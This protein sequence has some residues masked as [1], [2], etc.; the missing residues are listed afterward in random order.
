MNSP[1]DDA[2]DAG[3]QGMG[4]LE[5]IWVEMLY[6]S[7]EEISLLQSISFALK[8]LLDLCI[9]TLSRAAYFHLCL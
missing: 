8:L 9:V 2:C 5:G 3:R 1:Q 6:C 4:K 7:V